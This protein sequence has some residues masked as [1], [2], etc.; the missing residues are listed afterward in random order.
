MVQSFKEVI[1]RYCNVA[2][3]SYLRIMYS[4]DEVRQLKKRF[5]DGLSD[6]AEQYAELRNRRHK[7]MLHNTR[8]KGVT[9]KFDATRDGAYVILEIDHRSEEQQEKLYNHFL[10]NKELLEAAFDTPLV[11]DTHYITE[12][13]KPV[14]RIYCMQSGL[15]IH[16]QGEW[17]DFYAFMVDNM[18]R[19][20]KGFVQVKA[21]WDMW[22]G[23]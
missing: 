15:D 12:S 2:N 1:K 7:F 8:L 13:G 18:I 22:E 19:L 14:I 4:K 11:W 6:Y 17:G 21:I 20:E 23:A 10:E 5:W 9:M 3:I 16:R